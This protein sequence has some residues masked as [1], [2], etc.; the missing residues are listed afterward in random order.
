MKKSMRKGRKLKE[1]KVEVKFDERV[2]V[3]IE[4]IDIAAIAL[5]EETEQLMLGKSNELEG[6]LERKH[7]ADRVVKVTTKQLRDSGFELK[8]GSL[9][10]EMVERSLERLRNSAIA[11]AEAL[12]G[13]KNALDHVTSLIKR[14]SAQKGSEGMYNRKA[15]IVA[16][17][18]TTMLGFGAQI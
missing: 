6:F 18:E 15:V 16:S 5:D 4:A 2:N 14:A 17:R 12:Q 1:T 7:D 10:A 3:L 8:P 9:E 13:A 11:N